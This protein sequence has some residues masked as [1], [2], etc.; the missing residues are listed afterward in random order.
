M[1]TQRT[2]LDAWRRPHA[3]NRAK[4]SP[5][6]DLEAVLDALPV[7]VLVVDPVSANITFANR[8]SI[9]TMHALRQD[10]PQDVDPDRMVGTSMDVFH[11]NPQH[12]RS[13]VADPSRLPWHTKI[14]LGPKTLD[15]HVSAVMAQGASPQ[16]LIDI[17]LHVMKGLRGAASAWWA[18]GG[19]VVT[20]FAFLG[21]NMFL[22]GLHSYGTL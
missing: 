8:R 20:T 9:E 18:L 14:R 7:N 1:K 3:E 2:I 10:L 22:S 11:K 13:I 6:M 5:Q 16:P 4:V 19:L 15:L 17:N 12:Q 21:V